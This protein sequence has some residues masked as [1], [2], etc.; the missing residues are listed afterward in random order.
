MQNKYKDKPVPDI[1]LA[2]RSRSVKNATDAKLERTS[3]SAGIFQ[4][5]A[6]RIPGTGF[7]FSITHDF[8]NLSPYSSSRK[9]SRYD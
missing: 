1:L 5:S 6:H 8:F 3:L 9:I 4:S 7:L 2:G